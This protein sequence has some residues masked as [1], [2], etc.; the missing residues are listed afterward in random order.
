MHFWQSLQDQ[1]QQSAKAVVYG[2]PLAA[3]SM[4]DLASLPPMIVFD[5]L[6]E[7]ACSPTVLSKMI[8]LQR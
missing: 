1:Q 2:P 4:F 5:V 6:M 3:R 8:G 7:F